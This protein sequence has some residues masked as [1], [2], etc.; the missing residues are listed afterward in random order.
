VGLQIVGPRYGEALVLRAA[1]AFELA[2]PMT[3]KPPH[4]H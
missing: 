3:R 4:A 1:R 2:R